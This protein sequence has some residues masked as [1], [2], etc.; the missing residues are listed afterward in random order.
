MIAMM[1]RHGLKGLAAPQVGILKQLVVVR[2][3]GDQFIE[4]VNPIIKGMYGSEFQMPETCISCPPRDNGCMVARMQIIELVVSPV[5]NLESIEQLRF[6]GD[7]AR[8]IQHEI[9]HLDG[10][11]FFHRASIKDKT[12]VI[13][14]FN[15]WRHQWKVTNQK[16]T[17]GNDSDSTT[18]DQAAKADGIPI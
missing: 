14:R 6:K 13:N 16:E 8:V 5:Q 1:K 9:D 10:T 4:L 2:T 11:F 3:E 18:Q 7:I 12:A 15:N 17:H